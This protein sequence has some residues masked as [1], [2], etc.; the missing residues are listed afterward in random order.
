M[1][2]SD[3]N[4]RVKEWAKLLRKKGREEE[5]RFLIE[6]V[7]LVEEALRSGAPVEVLLFQSG[8]DYSLL[9]DL[10][11]GIET[12]EVSEAV[13]RKLA[14]TEET[15]GI[16]AVVRMEVEG[17]FS[18][19]LAGEREKHSSLLL[20]VDGVQDPGNLGTIIRTADAAGADGV[21]LGEGTVDLYNPKTV[22]ST[23]GSLFH[24]PIRS[25]DG[26]LALTKLK[27]AGYQTVAA[28][29]KG[30]ADYREVDYGERVVVLVGNEAHGLSPQL[31]E[32][33]QIRVRLPIYGKAESL[34]VAI[35][36]AL[37][38]YEVQ[39]GR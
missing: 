18:S 2:T 26:N 11:P 16:M 25:V 22:R 3:R 20:F 7:R 31:E 28:S 36:T 12:W 30:S 13:I 38:L 39:R 35:A 34:N 33:A 24:L 27:E 32:M 10:P 8:R 14:A 9:R 1:I 15:Q 5:K 19:F 17:P 23:M 4:P 6:G 29:L 21:L 37:M